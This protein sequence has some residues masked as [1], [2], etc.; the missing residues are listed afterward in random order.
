MARWA[1]AVG[2]VVLVSRAAGAGPRPAAQDQAAPP[3]FPAEVEQVTVDV[4]VVD[5]DGHP[6]TNL[7]SEDLEVYED[8][9]RQAIVSFDAVEVP[10]AVPAAAPIPTPTRVSTN[11][12]AKDARRGRSFV[13]VFDDLHLSPAR[14]LKAKSAVA[15]FLAKQTSEG[16]RVT[17]VA[18]GGGAWWTSRLPE[19]RQE[20][21]EAAKHLQG[22]LP[23]QTGRDHLSDY[24]AMRINVFRDTAIINRV[25]RRFETYG[26]MT[27]TQ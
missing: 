5:R 21:L 2:V 25:Q 4:V 12:T 10:A 7:K 16:D 9:V 24:E 15:E 3:S 22:R 17:L 1:V 26:M 27:V 20:L 19:G 13:I 8:G 6:V 18:A 14:A 23:P 11:A